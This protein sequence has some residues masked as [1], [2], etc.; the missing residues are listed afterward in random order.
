MR[1]E[2]MQMKHNQHPQSGS[3]VMS[4]KYYWPAFHE[5]GQKGY[6]PNQHQFPDD[7]KIIDYSPAPRDE[8]LVKFWPGHMV[9]GF[10]MPY[11]LFDRTQW[12]PSE[13]IVYDDSNW[14]V[15]P[16]DPAA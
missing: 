14:H 15:D 4:Y 6:K 9:P 11:T 5:D 3:T 16:D 10:D 12:I 13:F 7:G 8:Y 2:V 1:P